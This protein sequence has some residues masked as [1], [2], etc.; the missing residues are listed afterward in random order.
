MKESLRK[1]K[2][3]EVV[4]RN[5]IVM[6][7]AEYDYSKYKKHLSFFPEAEKSKKNNYPPD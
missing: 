4:G 7:L 6:N 5:L 2:K 3:S 1:I